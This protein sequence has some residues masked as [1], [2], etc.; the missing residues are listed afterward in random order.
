MFEFSSNVFPIDKMGG[1]FFNC[2][3]DFSKSKFKLKGLFS[4]I[5]LRGNCMFAFSSLAVDVP[6]DGEVDEAFTTLDDGEL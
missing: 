1:V 3:V 6:D 5:K 4:L 2:G